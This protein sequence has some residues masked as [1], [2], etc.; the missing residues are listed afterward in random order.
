MGSVVQLENLLTWLHCIYTFITDW[1][2]TLTPGN[3][4]QGR[5]FSFYLTISFSLMKR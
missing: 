1:T 5:F 4:V 2:I 3:I